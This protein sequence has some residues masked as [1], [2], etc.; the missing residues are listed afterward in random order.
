MTKPDSSLQVSKL[1]SCPVP[2]PGLLPSPGQHCQGEGQWEAK[3]Y[4]V[5]WP[6]VWG[7][8]TYTPLLTSIVVTPHQIFAILALVLQSRVSSPSNPLV[9]RQT[10]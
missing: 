8:R 7:W 3:L 2:L 5:S 10:S 9:L 6:G 4:C 1:P